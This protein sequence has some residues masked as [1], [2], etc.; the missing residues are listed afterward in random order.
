MWQ[1]NTAFT[2]NE[3]A[4]VFPTRPDSMILFEEAEVETVSGVG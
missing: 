1:E 4:D 2:S 3:D